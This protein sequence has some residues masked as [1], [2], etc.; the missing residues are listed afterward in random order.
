MKIGLITIYHVP[1][2]GSV[3]QTYATQ[4]VLEKLGN[5]CYIINYKYP[6]EWHKKQGVGKIKSWKG[7]IRHFIPSKK[8]LILRKFRITSYHFTKEYKNL[9]D[10]KSEDWSSYDAFIVGSDQVWNARF[11]LGDSA[12]LLSF[13]PKD[14]PRYSLASSFALNSLP[15]NFRSKY[16][17]ELSLFSAIS[18]R[19]LNGVNIIHNELKINKPVKVLLDP[20]LLLSKD[21]WLRIIK[22]SSFRKQKPYIVFYMLT[23]AFNPKPYI[24][25]VVNYFQRQMDCEIFALEGYSKPDVCGLE[26]Q[27]VSNSTIE[28]FIDLFAN[29]D[30]VI[31]SSFHG[32]AFALNF[33]IPLVS[34]VPNNYGDDRQITLLR[35]IGC[36][37][38]AIKKGT[39]INTINPKYDVEKEQTILNQLR[40]DNI[41]WIKNN[42]IY[43]K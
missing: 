29:A 43:A 14:K 7:F 20:T 16:Q 19:E 17:R 25:E 24:F 22:R 41:S 36:E 40:K 27:K 3:L 33:G 21:D 12:F 23:Y 2:Y 28:E 10:L 15:E 8:T 34:I 35:N 26:M 42:I 31:T 13:V 38:C 18:V 39:P 1:N 37:Q 4:Y 30:L 6:N 9:N 5:N 32:T 11:V